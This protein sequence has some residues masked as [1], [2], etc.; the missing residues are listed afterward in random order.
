[1]PRQI[2]LFVVVFALGLWCGWMANGWRLGIKHADFRR[3]QA[4]QIL[5]AR[6]EIRRQESAF[7]LSVKTLDQVYQQELINA[8]DEISRLRSDVRRGAVRLSVP[9]RC[10]RVPGD[11][12]TTGSAD[13]VSRA[14]IDPGAATEILALTERG[15][16]AI[17]QLSALQSYVQDVCVGVPVSD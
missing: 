10:E 3:E 16:R 12:R 11:T 8:Q 9:A 17:R 4:E 6:K 15:D 13:A 7:R 5:E 2:T 14:D 1:M